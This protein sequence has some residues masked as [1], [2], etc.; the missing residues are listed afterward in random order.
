[1]ARQAGE[2]GR[3]VPLRGSFG[4]FWER[5]LGKHRRPSLGRFLLALCR[6]YGITMSRL[7]F[8]SR[9]IYP[10]PLDDVVGSFCV[11]SLRR[12]FVRL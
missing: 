6:L 11:V 10:L 8:V 4:S 9:D 5:L 12:R 2:E 7:A 3:I 1:M